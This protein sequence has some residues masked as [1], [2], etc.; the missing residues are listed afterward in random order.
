MP[1]Y[2]WPSAQR[3]VR[4]VRYL[5]HLVILHRAGELFEVLQFQ[6]LVDPQILGFHSSI[7]KKKFRSS[8]EIEDF[9]ETHLSKLRV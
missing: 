5:S 3:V 6:I 7:E 8:C 2:P 9:V 4:V 1:F